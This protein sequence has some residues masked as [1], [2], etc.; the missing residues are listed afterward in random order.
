M[1]HLS[2]L[3]VDKLSGRRVG[4]RAGSGSVKKGLLGCLSL[5]ERREEYNCF[6]VRA[7]RWQ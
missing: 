1:N 7:G 3:Q 6:L 2:P 5:V 4:Y